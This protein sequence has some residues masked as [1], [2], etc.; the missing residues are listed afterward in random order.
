MIFQIDTITINKYIDLLYYTQGLIK[1]LT[2]ETPI[3]ASTDPQLQDAINFL[4]NIR[5]CDK[6]MYIGGDGDCIK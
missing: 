1:G 6:L 5:D 4:K 2:N 3:P